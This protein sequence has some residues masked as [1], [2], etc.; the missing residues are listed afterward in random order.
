MSYS[1]LPLLNASLN[2]ITGVLLVVGF[3][4]IKKGDKVKHK[5]WMISALVSSTLF[6]I[7]YLFYHYNVGSIPYPHHDWTRT[8][9]FIILIPHVI[10][11]GVMLPFIIAGV[12]YAL[13][14]NFVKHKKLMRIVF[15]IWLYVSVTGVIVYLMLYIL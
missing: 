14:D 15:P 8:L 6:L 2:L 13:R 12:T 10:L 4:H 5:K 9:Y 7:S 1:D 11:A 3:M